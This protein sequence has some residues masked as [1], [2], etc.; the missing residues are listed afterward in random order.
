MLALHT[1]LS[2]PTSSR[3]D[4]LASWAPWSLTLG[5]QE[6]TG[7]PSSPILSPHRWPDT[8][9][10][11]EREETMERRLAKTL[12]ALSPFGGKSK[13]CL[14][15]MEFICF[16]KTTWA[17]ESSSHL[18]EANSSQKGGKSLS[19]VSQL[20]PRGFACGNWGGGGQ[21]LS[22]GMRN[23]ARL[24]PKV[25]PIFEQVAESKGNFPSLNTPT[26]GTEEG[27]GERGIL[28]TLFSRGPNSFVCFVKD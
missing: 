16:Y 26:A 5:M 28:C 6:V 27:K 3:R 24:S 10:V 9:V 17:Q 14:L 21:K 8:L 2:G 12:A 13:R 20:I 11:L 22:S 25:N 19:Y 1:P 23:L 4:L 18:S 7:F 15:L